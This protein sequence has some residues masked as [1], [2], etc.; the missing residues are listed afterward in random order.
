MKRKRTKTRRTRTSSTITTKRRKR[1]KRMSGGRF[2]TAAT[3]V[4]ALAGGMGG[5]CAPA[6][7]QS[8][9]GSDAYAVVAVSVFREP[10]FALPGAKVTLEPDPESRPDSKK[11]LKALH[12][13]T[14][15]R[16]EYAFRVPPG[17]AR[18]TLTASAKE[19]HSA[20]KSV[21]VQGQERIDVTVTLSP[22]SNE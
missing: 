14:S 22:S 9:A 11:R 13:I 16:G 15:P 4:F 3:L 18:Y 1:K 6:A 12:G 5:L 17:P 21:E 7:A 2:G 8:G 20:T 10:G 19:Y